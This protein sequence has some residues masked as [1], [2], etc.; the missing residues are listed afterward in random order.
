MMAKLSKCFRCGSREIEERP[1]EQLVRQGRYVV[2]L[3][4][5][6]DVCSSCGERYFEGDSVRMFESVKARIQRGDLEGFRVTGELLEPVTAS[7]R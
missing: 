6:A 1:V 5:P 4:V 7:S 3:R 2:A